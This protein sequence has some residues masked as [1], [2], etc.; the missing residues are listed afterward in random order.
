LIACPNVVDP[1]KGL[2]AMVSAMAK[3]ILTNELERDESA[4]IRK[5]QESIATQTVANPSRRH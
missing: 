1:L 5:V 2:M 3:P 4:C